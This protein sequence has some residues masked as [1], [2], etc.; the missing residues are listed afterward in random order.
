MADAVF[1]A[2]FKKIKFWSHTG[3]TLNSLLFI[4]PL[5]FC[6][7]VFS[8]HIS[9]TSR[10]SEI[11]CDKCEICAQSSAEVFIIKKFYCLRH[12][13]LFGSDSVFWQW[14]W[15]IIRRVNASNSRSLSQRGT[16]VYLTPYQSSNAL[17]SSLNSSSHASNE[18]WHTV[19]LVKSPMT[20]SS[21]VTLD[22]AL[23]AFSIV[24]V[25]VCIFSY[26]IC[27]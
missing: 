8:Y 20:G 11:R 22:K 17:N 3:Q 10:E 4:P 23:T 16:L 12:F 21:D 26:H 2:A 13:W 25:C 19:G 7:R 15:Q 14:P 27:L 9:S 5:A 6:G 1:V 24:C 18:P